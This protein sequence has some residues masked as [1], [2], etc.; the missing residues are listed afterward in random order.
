MAKALVIPAVL[1]AST[2]SGRT[3]SSVKLGLSGRTGARV[4][5]GARAGSVRLFSMS[6]MK[7][8]GCLS[9]CARRVLGAVWVSRATREEQLAGRTR[10]TGV[11]SG[12]DQPRRRRRP[13]YPTA[14]TTTSKR[15]RQCC[16]RRLDLR[17]A[18]RTR[19]DRA[20]TG[21]WTFGR[22]GGPGKTV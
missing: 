17:S 11:G 18:R 19:E 20:A 12:I 1:N 22:R 16:Y 4:S 13:V 8:Y 2:V 5:T 6:V 9:L 21:A 7:F 10:V 14:E 3:P 15:E